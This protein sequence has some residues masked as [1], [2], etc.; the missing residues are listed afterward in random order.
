[1]FDFET[2]HIVPGLTCNLRCPHCANDSAPEQRGTLSKTE[3]EAISAAIN[4]ARPRTIV[5]TGGEPTIYCEPINEIL[6]KLTYQPK[7][8]LTT[9]GTYA[10]NIEQARA[11]LDRLRFVDV[12]QLSFDPHHDST[13]D[14]P[15]PRVLKQYCEE[16]GVAFVVIVSLTR[17][18]DITFAS[19]VEKKYGVKVIIQKI[20]GSGRARK[21]GVEFEYQTFDRAVLKERCPNSDAASYIQGRGFTVCC[22][23]VVYNLPGKQ[24]VEKDLADLDANEFHQEVTRLSFA[25]R[26]TKYGIS[27]SELAPRH[28]SACNL[29]ELIELKACKSKVPA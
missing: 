5:L 10:L 29:C 8:I 26:M 12:I 4:R 14:S 20:E 2:F 17:L 3:R 21:T 15:V 27:A 6:E 9:N 25:E 23:N 16:R 22:S 28:S 24:Y 19:E 11:K 13:L 18:T 1:M 7:V